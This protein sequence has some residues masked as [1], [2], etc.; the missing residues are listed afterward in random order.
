[1][2]VYTVIKEMNT[3]VINPELQNIESIYSMTNT[4]NRIA[5]QR[6][7]NEIVAIIRNNE[8]ANTKTYILL[9]KELNTRPTISFV[10]GC[11][12]TSVISTALITYLILSK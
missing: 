8:Y 2:S 9:L 12:F 10:I 6:N 11:L 4:Y 1:M 3:T 7:L 5:V